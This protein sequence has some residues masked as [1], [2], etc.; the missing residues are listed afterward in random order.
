MGRNLNSMNF[1]KNKNFFSLY[2]ILIFSLFSFLSFSFCQAQDA[3]TILPG[4]GSAKCDCSQV[5]TEGC[6]QYCGSYELND[7]ANLAV[8]ASQWILGIVGSLALLMFVYGGVMFLIS[9]GNSEKVTQAKGIILGAVIGIVIVF[10]SYMIIG[11][12]FKATGAD[13]SGTAWSQVG[14]FK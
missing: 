7:F 4:A 5:I 11:F 12:V 3:D 13:M 10:T 6:K 14:W 8:I 2:F 1:I 9:A